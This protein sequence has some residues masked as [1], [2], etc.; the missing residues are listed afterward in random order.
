MFSQRAVSYLFFLACLLTFASARPVRRSACPA[1]AVA[2]ATTSSKA[3]LNVVKASSTAASTSTTK[4]S[5]KT[6]STAKTTTTKASSSTKTTSTKAAAS[7]STPALSI[8]GTLARL[9]PVSGIS[10]SWTTFPSTGSLALADSTFRPFDVLSSVVHTYTKAPDGKSAIMANYPKGSYT[11]GHNPQGGFSFYAPGPASVDLTTAKEATFGYSVFFPTGFDFNKGGKLPGLYGGDSAEEAV[12]CSGGSRSAACFS[13]RLMW[14]T[15]GA[16]ELYTYLP[17][18]TE[19]QFAVNNRVCDVAPLSE[20]NPTYGASVGRGSFKFAT[21]AWTTISER[22]RL[23]DVGQA[24]GELELFA[25][26]VSVISVTGLI[27]RDSAA[28]R[29]RGMQMQTFFGGSSVDFASPKDQ[30]LYFSDFS[31]S[32]T[33]SL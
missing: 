31:V 5:T 23:N 22:V 19:S 28:G 9:F 4:A 21:G 11:F 26:G 32:I 6:S 18:Y 12:G 27:L 33:E 3:S 15:A 30:D 24:N 16:G 17:P 29:F 7:T 13:A 10:K 2:T 14:R 20:C 1:R 25:N 8:T